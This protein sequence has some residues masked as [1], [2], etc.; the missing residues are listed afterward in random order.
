MQKE[1]LNISLSSSL[2]YGT[3]NH[4]I[5][6]KNGIRYH[7]GWFEDY[8]TTPLLIEAPNKITYVRDSLM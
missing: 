5:L 4:D 2:Q 6:M 8:A 1:I 7:I 3:L